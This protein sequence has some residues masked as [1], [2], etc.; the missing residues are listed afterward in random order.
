MA[1]AEWRGRQEALSAVVAEKL[2]TLA[3]AV[4]RLPNDD[5][6]IT[7]I[8]VFWDRL[9]ASDVGRRWS[10]IEAEILRSI[11][12]GVDFTGPRP[13]LDALLAK[14]RDSID[15]LTMARSEERRVGKECV[16]TG[17]SRGA[18]VTKK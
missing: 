9:E 7:E 10:E 17:R 11:G 18:P 12:Y 1:T 4:R 5:P 2:V 14:Y 16:S 8:L 6:Q 13:F 15:E 3:S